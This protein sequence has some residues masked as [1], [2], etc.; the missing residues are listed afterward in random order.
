M[1]RRL[2][3]HEKREL[4]KK[5][6]A[7]EKRRERIERKRKG[8]I[9]RVA[10]WSAGIF[11]IVII[12]YLLFGF[13][14][15]QKK[16]EIK[17]SR[18][19]EN[20]P[21]IQIEPEFYDFGEV[22]V[23]KGT[24]TALLTVK[25]VGKNDLIIDYMETSCMCTEVSLIVDGKE[26][27]KFGMRMH[28]TNPVNWWENLTSGEEAKLKVYYN[29]RVHSELRGALTRIITIHSNDPWNSKKEVRIEAYQV[30]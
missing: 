9:R 25:N 4:R 23:R 3:T 6:R 13:F 2:T 18:G 22:S 24:V 20:A 1:K 12:S 7:N 5:E 19:D 28:G 11:G 17:Y 15:S 16:P 26:S 8:K 21:R 27:P 14:S 10:Y 29:P 30:S